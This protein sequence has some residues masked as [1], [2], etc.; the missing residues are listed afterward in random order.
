M[1][2]VDSLRGV[3]GGAPRGAPPACASVLERDE[4]RDDDGEERRTLDERRQNQRTRLNGAGDL[5]LA[6]HTFGRRAADPA[7][8]KSSADDGQTRA[9]TGTEHRP[10]ALI[11]R[12]VAGLGRRLQERKNTHCK[13]PNVPKRETSAA[14]R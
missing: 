4:Q 11:T 7:D 13:S 12:I 2:R 5:R 6:S 3:A 8:A 10:G 14:P 9:D 1:A